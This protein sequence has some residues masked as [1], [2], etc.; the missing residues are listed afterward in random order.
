MLSLR[1]AHRPLAMN[2]NHLAQYVSPASDKSEAEQTISFNHYLWLLRR[3]WWKILLIVV[4]CTTLTAAIC[5]VITPIYEATARIVID[6]RVPSTALGRDGDFALSSSE[7]DQMINTEIQLIQSDVVLRPVAERYHLNNAEKKINA[8]APA[9]IKRLKISH[10]PNSLIINISYRSPDRKRAALIA[11]AVAHS[12]INAS[13]EM[14]ARFSR[15]LSFFMEKQIDELK[16]NM[17][18]SAKALAGYEKELGV[19][20]P[21]EKTSILSARLIQLNTEYT[22]AENDRI[23]KEAAYRAILSGSLAALEVSPQAEALAKLQ[24]G[25]RTAQEK[26]ASIKTI[27]GPN[28][29]EYRRVANELQELTSQYNQMRA[30]VAQRITT[31]YKQAKRREEI[32]QESLANAKDESDKLNAN[33]A[34]YQQLKREAE[35]N[36]ALYEELFRKIKEAGINAGFQGGAIRIADEAR[37]EVAPVFPDTKVFIF[38]GFLFSLAAS[39]IVILLSDLFEKGLR[40]PEQARRVLNTDVLGVLPDVHEFATSSRVRLI[41]NGDHNKKRKG[42]PVKEFFRSVSFYE[43]AISALRSTILLDRSSHKLHSI[44]VTSATSGEGKSTCA[45]HLAIAHA[46]QGKKTLLIDAD[47]RRPSQHNLFGLSNENGVARAIGNK[48]DFAGLPQAIREIE[49]LFVIPS[50]DYHL[51]RFDLVGSTIADILNEIG[52]DYDLVIIDTPPMQVLA[53]PIQIAGMVDSVVVVAQAGATS[54]QAVAGLLSTLYRIRSKVSSVVLNRVRPDMSPAY[55]QYNSYYR[56]SA[57]A[58]RN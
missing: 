51:R 26:M 33:S 43:E 6:N 44:M 13:L 3:H 48:E 23:R 20:N 46:G 21:D 17:D 47:L 29:V 15:G 12:Y 42:K 39:V 40:D 30:D 54:R 38:L 37:P 9:T 35:A 56:Y 34:Q 50:G 57:K 53:E 18:V 24:D 7:I 10:P 1:T 28:Y 32:L 2:D 14:R 11:N 58:I 49:H 55:Q 8:D 45:A 52:G 36:K 5:N 4:G 27:Y 41:S 16:S 19:V 25:I 31:E 22:E